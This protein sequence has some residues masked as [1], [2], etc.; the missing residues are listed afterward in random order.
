MTCAQTTCR[1][2]TSAPIAAAACVARPSPPPAGCWPPGQPPAACT[3]SHRTVLPVP[4]PADPSYASQREAY[5]ETFI[6]AMVYRTVKAGRF[7]GII[8]DGGA[9]PRN[10]GR[11]GRH[12]ADAPAWGCNATHA[13][14]SGAAPRSR[15]MSCPVCR[16]WDGRCAGSRWTEHRDGNPASC[17]ASGDSW[18]RGCARDGL[19]A[20]R[21]RM[22]FTPAMQSGHRF[23]EAALLPDTGPARQGRPSPPKLAR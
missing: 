4:C 18:C 7:G 16:R 19:D 23:L 12:A 9:P 2:S 6:N 10:S 13:Y 8:R 21:A 20:Y 1:V 15:T 17:N 5:L 22:A 3:S 11:Q 14:R